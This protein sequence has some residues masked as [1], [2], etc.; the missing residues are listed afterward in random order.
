MNCPTLTCP[1]CNCPATRVDCG[2]MGNMDVNVQLQ[3]QQQ[4]TVTSVIVFTPTAANSRNQPF[5]QRPPIPS[6]VV[7]KADDCIERDLV[8]FRSVL[9]QAPTFA[10]RISCPGNEKIHVVKAIFGIF[11][12]E[13]ASRCPK[14]LPEVSPDFCFESVTDTL[15]DLC[16]GKFGSC[17]FPIT[18]AVLIPG[19]PSPCRIGSLLVLDVLFTCGRTGLRRFDIDTPLSELFGDASVE[20]VL[21]D[22]RFEKDTRIRDTPLGKVT[23]GNF[24]SGGN[25]FRDVVYRSNNDNGSNDNNN[26]DN[27]SNDYDDNNVDND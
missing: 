20:E 24:F 18:N 11:P 25:L 5:C 12:G 9:C 1:D 22:L 2:D 3:V 26:D 13:E 7:E 10:G 15:G 8:T 6:R 19:R 14:G 16:N 27:N 21:G 17:D 23:V 4:Q